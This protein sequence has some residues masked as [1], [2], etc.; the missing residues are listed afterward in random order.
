M[1]FTNKLILMY[2]IKC[3]CTVYLGAISARSLCQV[4]SHNHFFP[5]PLSL[6]LSLSLFFVCVCGMYIV[7]CVV[8]VCV[9]KL[10]LTQQPFK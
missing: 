6:S 7:G 5:S 1:E 8:C 10:V 9:S 4:P 3:S 2:S